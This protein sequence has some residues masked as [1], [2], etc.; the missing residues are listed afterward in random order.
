MHYG[1]G[2]PNVGEHLD[3]LTLAHLAQDAEAA[4]W[5]GF[6]LWD[7]VVP[8][9]VVSPTLPVV[10]PWIALTA[11]ALRTRTIRIGPLVTPLP[12]R[13]PT[14]LARETVSLDQLSGGR[15]TLGVG[16]GDFLYEWDYLGEVAD[17]RVRGAMLDEALE[18]VT[19]LWTG[20][21]F[22]YRGAHYTVAG[23]PPEEAWQ[24]VFLPTPLQQPRIPIWVAGIWPNKAPFRRAARW[25]GACPVK[26]DGAMTPSDVRELVAY[27]MRYRSS[28]EPFDVVIGGYTLA[29]EDGTSVATLAQCAEA[30]ATW[31]VEDLGPWRFAGAGDGTAALEQLQ[32]RIRLGPPAA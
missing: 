13:R 11:I 10:D 27:I 31:W 22:S 23:T 30:G 29:D 8:A 2:V 14:K 32:A 9:A 28:S 4:G 16:I 7:H 17:K 18:V 19:G 25:D 3:A 6:F 21:P 24:T 26:W 5:E 20:Q 15:L 1:L 12:R